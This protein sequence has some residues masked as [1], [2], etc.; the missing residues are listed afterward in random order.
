ME[1]R[2]SRVFEL[3]KFL[4]S[5]A[6]PVVISAGALLKDNKTGAMIAQLK[7][8]NIVSKKIKAVKISLKEYDT[9]G[10][11]FDGVVTY[12]Y[13]DLNEARNAEFG[14]KVPV[15]LS[16]NKARSF[17]VTVDK[18]V[19]ED[20]STWEGTAEPWISL[21]DQN[22]LFSLLKS[23][24]LVKQYCLEFDQRC[25]FIPIEDRDIWMCSCGKINKND[26]SSCHNC[27]CYL[28]EMKNV[29]L[30]VLE[31]KK[32]SRLLEEEKERQIRQKDLK[33]KG[34]IL[35]GIL[36]LLIILMSCCSNYSKKVER[37]EEAVSLISSSSLKDNEEGIEILSDL[38]KFKD[39][40]DL[41]YNKAIELAGKNYTL[42]IDTLFDIIDYKDSKDILYQ[43]A[44]LSITSN[45]EESI[46]IFKRLGDYKDSK[47]KIKEA[48]YLKAESDMEKGY[49]SNALKYYEK[50]G[51]Y[52]DSKEKQKTAYLY[53][54]LFATN[55]GSEATYV[56][57]LLDKLGLK[58]MTG[59]EI[60]T[61]IIGQ[62]YLR[63]NTYPSN[64]YI[65][66]EDGTFVRKY[67]SNKWIDSKTA[68]YTWAVEN[69]ELV[70]ISA[71]K[72]TSSRSKYKLVLV[73]DGVI[74]SYNSSNEKINGIYFAKDG[75]L[76]EKFLSKQTKYIMNE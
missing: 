65:F 32:K 8:R 51:D 4:Y 25:E 69:D 72:E 66:N 27:G 31:E 60:K 47:E 7:F 33:K 75:A 54:R 71:G 56:N 44:A 70:L 35:G 24:E 37:Y 2:Y 28:N 40:K 59:D 3:P 34:L 49:Y 57:E 36:I 19:F 39:S 41:I 50:A 29:D 61:K 17:S 10:E 26:E 48:P 9:V 42:G 14:Q 74:V 18:V 45:C 55:Y 1:E 38:G 11:P 20:N 22:K 53:K 63:T 43:N 76:T 15:K 46:S 68:E 13:L 62:W 5:E 12:E 58:P 16:E 67:Y 6:S 30:E 64:Y 73:Q 21:P 23:D 52:K